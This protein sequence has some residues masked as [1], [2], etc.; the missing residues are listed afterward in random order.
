MPYIKQEHR[1]R[2]DT[3]IKQLINAIDTIENKD[4]DGV[5]NYVISRLASE[6]MGDVTKYSVIARIVG[7]FECAKLEFYRRI[8]GPKEDKAITENGDV[9]GPT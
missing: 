7:L 9:Y 2:V 6:T 5:L 1:D 8:A 3:Q 4:S